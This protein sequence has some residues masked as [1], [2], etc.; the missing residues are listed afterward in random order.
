[1]GRFHASKLSWETHPVNV[2]RVTNR[3]MQDSRLGLSDHKARL[4]RIARMEAAAQHE[5]VRAQLDGEPS[6]LT[7]SG[8]A[9]GIARVAPHLALAEAPDQVE[10]AAN[11]EAA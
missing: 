7:V 5:Y 11:E 3:G 10:P 6:Q 8:L 4:R 2:D 9:K 1:M